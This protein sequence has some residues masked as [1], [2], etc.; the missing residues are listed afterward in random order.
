MTRAGIEKIRA[1]PGS[2]VLDI[3]KLAAARGQD[4]IE[5]PETMMIDERSINPC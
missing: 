2:L 1:Y 5:L 4:P 3:Q